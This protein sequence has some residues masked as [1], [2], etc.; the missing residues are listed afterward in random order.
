MGLLEPHGRYRQRYGRA[1]VSGRLAGIARHG[2]SRGP[3]ET[4]DSVEVTPE[5]GI[6]GDFR[7]WIKP[8]GKGRRQVT[9]IEAG[10]WEA[11]MAD[12]GHSLPWW[13]R[14]ANLLVEGLDLPQ[15]EGALLRIGDDVVLRVTVECD[16]C[17]RMEEVA[18]GLKAALTPD[19]RGGA[20]ARVV[21]GGRIAVGDVVRIEGTSSPVFV[22]PAKAGTQGGERLPGDPGSPLS[23]G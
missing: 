16:P 2:R 10:D 8:G 7:G 6:H 11:A 15:E 21:R 9:L 13:E 12:I 19:W 20:C 3:M 22:I 18:E 23:R 4:V 5:E 14:R 17:S 1:G